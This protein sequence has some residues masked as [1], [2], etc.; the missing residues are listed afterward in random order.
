[1]VKQSVVILFGGISSEHEVA[2]NSAASILKNIDT[3]LWD[4]Y[5]VGIAKDGSWLL[6]EASPEEIENGSWLGHELNQ[7]VTISANRKYSG[8]YNFN[9]GET[10]KVDCIFPVLHGMFGEDGTV[11]GLC[12]VAGIPYVGCDV[13]S[14]ALS[15]DKALTKRIVNETEITQADYLCFKKG[16]IEEQAKQIKEYFI[17]KYPLFVKPAKGGSSV[18]I[19]RVPNEDAITDALEEAYK[20]D[21]SIVVEEGIT[22][23]EI[24]VAVLGYDYQ[25]LIASNIGEIIV[26]DGFYS[27]ASKY[28]DE[29]V[30]IVSAQT[31]IITDLED[32]LVNEIKE[33]AKTVYAT[34]G[35]KG[36]SRVDFFLTP[37]NRVIFNE[38]NTMPGFTKIS[39]YPKLM[40]GIGIKYR[41]LITTLIKDA[42]ANYDL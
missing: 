42:I 36:L 28:G 3:E 8:L 12:E 20:Y 34:L 5:K 16:D 24:E 2:C 30:G 22:G 15:M 37:D 7:D 31:R 39:M 29:E 21:H 13:P 23:R 32:K 40:D 6:T 1:M 9:T 17:G 18:G 19:S 33:D 41:D 27:Y 38:I 4:V 14:S 25:N 11:Q 26:Q 35:C 10:Y